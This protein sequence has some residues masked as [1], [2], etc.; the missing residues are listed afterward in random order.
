[1]SEQSA[2]ILL[3]I[4]EKLA[5]LQVF[6]DELRQERLKHFF[7]MQIALAGAFAISIQQFLTAGSATQKIAFCFFAFGA[8]FL[9]ERFTRTTQALNAR[10]TE[11]VMTV[12]NQLQ[13]VEH[14]LGPHISEMDFLPYEGQYKVL[15]ERSLVLNASGAYVSVNDKDRPSS[16]DRSR[17]A[18]S[19][20]DFL[21]TIRYAWLFALCALIA[22]AIRT[23]F[24][25]IT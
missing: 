1:M 13:H 17:A 12:K 9:G 20:A 5:D 10:A 24:Y 25:G 18:T 22:L 16:Q 11:Y 3:R 19:E 14:L 7:P 8:W 15:N 6:H 2:D 4:W 21:S 23:T